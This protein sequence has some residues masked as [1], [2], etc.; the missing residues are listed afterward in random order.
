MMMQIKL[1]KK[2]FAYPT[3]CKSGLSQGCIDKLYTDTSE[4]A[5]ANRLSG[6]LGFCLIKIDEKIRKSQEGMG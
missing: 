5:G 3:V 1:V 2:K 4:Y 6:K